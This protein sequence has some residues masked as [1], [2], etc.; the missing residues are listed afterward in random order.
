MYQV[1]LTKFLISLKKSAFKKFEPGI[2]GKFHDQW[3]AKWIVIRGQLR[4]HND[5]PFG[6]PTPGSCESS[7]AGRCGSVP[8]PGEEVWMVMLSQI[9]GMTGVGGCWPWRW[10]WC[11]S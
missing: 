1:F 7:C 3:D 2:K 5:T 10:P 9:L 6:H 4:G 8:P 11:W